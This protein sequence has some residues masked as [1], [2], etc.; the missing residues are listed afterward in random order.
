MKEIALLG[1]TGSIGTQTLD[2]VRSS[3]GSFRVSALCAGRSWERLLEQVREFQPRVVGLADP[4]AAARLRDVLPPGTALV[5]GP[6]AAVEIATE[7]AYDIAV[8]GI[9]GAAGVLPSCGVLSSGRT[10]A[11]ANKESLVVAGEPLMELARENS[12][13]ILPVDSEHCALF[14]CLRDE[15]LGRVRRVLLTASGG[16]FRD[17]PLEKLEQAT[18]E[19]ALRHPNWDMGPRITVGSATLMNKAFE[20]IETHH[21]FGLE[22]ERI[23]VVL[24]RQSVCHSMV[25]FCDGSVLAQLSPPDMRGP[26]HFALHWPDRAPTTLKGFDIEHFHN[27]TFE[28]INRE[29]FPALELGYE[30]VRLGGTAGASLNAADEVGVEAFLEGRIG[31]QEMAQLSRSV[32][33]KCSAPLAPNSGAEAIAELLSADGAARSLARKEVA[34]REQS[35]VR[36]R[37]ARP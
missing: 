5:E 23:E 20:V 12:A 22:P 4:E 11:L 29:R 15:D 8:H 34:R 7:A 28:E 30:A 3:A 2:I 26:I 18:P 37:P 31:F 19:M 21:L 27:L 24:H 16:A 17:L 32:L 9:V 1:S 14:Q 13:L 6:Q 25:E 35:G 10:L 33:E 36:F